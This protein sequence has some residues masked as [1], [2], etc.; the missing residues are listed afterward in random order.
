M[1]VKF[2]QDIEGIE[3]V[4]QPG[5]MFITGCDTETRVAFASKIISFEPAIAWQIVKAGE[6]E[7]TI[8]LRIARVGLEPHKFATR[9]SKVV[10]LAGHNPV[11]I[12]NGPA[13]GKTNSNILKSYASNLALYRKRNNLPAVTIRSSTW[14]IVPGYGG[15][16]FRAYKVW[17]EP[18]YAG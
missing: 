15:D 4:Y 13:V 16:P 2:M 9:A 17:T 18:K 7:Q 10:A 5:E 11:F 8:E 14:V 6:P 3:E 1:R 12:T